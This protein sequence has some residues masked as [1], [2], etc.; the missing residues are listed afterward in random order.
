MKL[1]KIK[2]WL[3]SDKAQFIIFDRMGGLIT[4]AQRIKDENVFMRMDF[5]NSKYGRGIIMEF[6]SNLIHVHVCGISPGA[7]SINDICF[8]V[9]IND[10]ELDIVP[11]HSADDVEATRKR[12]YEHCEQLKK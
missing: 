1:L 12:V 7:P 3:Q 4:V 6:D 5:I 9:E 8:C 10:I 11:V 2:Q